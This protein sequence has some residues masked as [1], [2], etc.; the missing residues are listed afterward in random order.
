MFESIHF[1]SKDRAVTNA[2]KS[3][4]LENLR[5]IAGVRSFWASPH[6]IFWPNN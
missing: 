3:E 4:V 5:G 6:L 1:K 2:F